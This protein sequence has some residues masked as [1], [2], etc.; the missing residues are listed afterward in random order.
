MVKNSQEDIRTGLQ[1]SF[2]VDIFSFDKNPL[3]DDKVP[4]HPQLGERDSGERVQTETG[5]RRSLPTER[6]GYL[7]GSYQR[8]PTVLGERTKEVNTRETP[9]LIKSDISWSDL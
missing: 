9:K 1:E 6:E 5:E 3:P 7:P 2:G 4:L 8:V